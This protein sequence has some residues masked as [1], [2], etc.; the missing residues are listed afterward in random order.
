MCAPGRQACCEAGLLRGLLQLSHAE[1]LELCDV[2][3]YMWHAD[4]GSHE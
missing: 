2:C 4:Q 3:L 1:L